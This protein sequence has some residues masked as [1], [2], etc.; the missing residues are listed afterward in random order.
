MKAKLL[1]FLLPLTASFGTTVAQTA[2]PAYPQL[3]A[4]AE[5]ELQAHDPCAATATFEQAF[6]PDST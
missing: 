1:L 5:T 2:A 6:A 3:L 4:R